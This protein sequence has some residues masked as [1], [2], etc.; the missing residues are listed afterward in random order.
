[1][2]AQLADVRSW[3][4]FMSTRLDLDPARFA[5]HE[6]QQQLDALPSSVPF[7]GDRI[8]LHYEV[9]RGAAVVRL[10]LREGKARRIRAGA[11]PVLDRPVRFTVLR[12]RNE[13]LHAATIEELQAGLGRLGGTERRVRDGRRPGR[14][15]P[16]R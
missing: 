8:P 16:R 9:E 12:G 6:S 10:R 2:A 4:A 14:R 5:D 11:L 15:R 7:L 3:E 13:V 1:L